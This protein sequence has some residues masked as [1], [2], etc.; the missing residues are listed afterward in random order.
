[1]APRREE[2][3]QEGDLSGVLTTAGWAGAM[4]L[5]TRDRPRLHSSSSINTADRVREITLM[6][7][8]GTEREL[9][10]ETEESSSQL[11]TAD[12][13][14]LMLNARGTRMM[15]KDLLQPDSAARVS[16][17]RTTSM[18]WLTEVPRMST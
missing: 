4:T 16:W 1:M 10:G 12:R 13:T 2:G 14:S 7:T 6:I 18:S 5:M 3:S 11:P 17:S 15:T 8:T 9:G